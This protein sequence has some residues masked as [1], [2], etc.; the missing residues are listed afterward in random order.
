MSEK[1]WVE[2]VDLVNGSID[3]L[4]S[5]WENATD[6]QRYV[7]M[8]YLA[9]KR[10]IGRGDRGYLLICV[11]SD[12]EYMCENFDERTL[13]QGKKIAED[14]RKEIDGHCKRNVGKLMKQCYEDTGL[15]F[16]S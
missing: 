5:V 11:E 7:V 12:Y 2:T 13:L 15:D 9:F 1:K 16:F 6:Y 4:M 3:T 10:A 8:G 14:F